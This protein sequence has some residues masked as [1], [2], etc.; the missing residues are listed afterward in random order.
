MASW[1][2]RRGDTGGAAGYEV[3]LLLETNNK[4]A[5][6]LLNDVEY[7]I[8]SPKS[9]ASNSLEYILKKVLKQSPSIIIDISRLKKIHEKSILKFFIEQAR[10]RKQIKKVIVITRQ[11][12]VI[13]VSSM[14]WYNQSIEALA[15]RR[16]YLPRELLFFVAPGRSFKLAIRRHYFCFAKV[17]LREPRS[18]RLPSPRKKIKND[19]LGRFLFFLVAPGRSLRSLAVATQE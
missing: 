13:D 1:A 3:K 10:I 15:R 17:W 5:D 12:R 16:R 18:A 19:P 7:E 6:I 14:I 11:G 4:T 8:K 2:S 9:S